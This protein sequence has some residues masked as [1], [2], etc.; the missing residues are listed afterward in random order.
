MNY[1]LMVLAIMCLVKMDSVGS[2]ACV[3][4][5]GQL[6]QINRLVMLTLMNVL[7]D[8]HRVRQT[9]SSCVSTH[10]DHLSVALAQQDFQATV[11]RALTLMNV[12]RTMAAAPRLHVF[13]AP[14]RSARVDVLAAQT[15]ILVMASSAILL[16]FVVSTTAAVM[17]WPLVVK[18]QV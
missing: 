15:A 7:L 14:T 18:L 13:S 12:K 9:L 6:D 3:T 4:L 16:V 5:D 1:V 2:A 17:H 11:L 8:V 10:L